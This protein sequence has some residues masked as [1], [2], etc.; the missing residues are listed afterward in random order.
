MSYQWDS[1]GIGKKPT[2]KL[3]VEGAIA[4]GVLVVTASSDNLDVSLVTIVF[5]NITSNIILGG[6]T[7]GV[8]GQIVNFVY[9]GNYTATATFEDTEGVG[10]Q[11]FYMHTR[12][13]E[14]I[15]GGGISMIC[16]GSN[17]YDGSHARHV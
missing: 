2:C 1:L 14:T 16:D 12:A 10:D 8:A 4:G 3:D 13:D 17:W 5:I 7:G 9:K 6:C 11:D 15:D